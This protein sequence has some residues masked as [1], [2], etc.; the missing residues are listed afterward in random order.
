MAEYHP[1]LCYAYEV[2]DVFYPI[3]CT[4]YIVYLNIS[5]AD[6]G[7]GSER[8][9]KYLYIIGKYRH[10]HSSGPQYGTVL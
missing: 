5:S 3:L 8:I 10:P 2:Y 6:T 9:L 4:I 7:L 1:A